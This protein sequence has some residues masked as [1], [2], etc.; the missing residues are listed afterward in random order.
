MVCF[1]QRREKNYL[2]KEEENSIPR[3]FLSFFTSLVGRRKIFKGNKWKVISSSLLF[4]LLC[5]PNWKKKLQLTRICL[6]LTF[7]PFSSLPLIPSSMHSVKPVYVEV[8]SC[9]KRKRTPFNI[10][11][12]IVSDVTAVAMR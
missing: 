10:S 2:M 9:T 3:I 6:F 4:L 5:K 12:R 11:S 8:L 1:W 7:P